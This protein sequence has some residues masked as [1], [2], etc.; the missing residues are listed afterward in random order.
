[1]SI[2]FDWQ[3][4][5]CERHATI[6][7][8]NYYEEFVR[9]GL[10]KNVYGRSVGF[11]NKMIVCPNNDCKEVVAATILQTYKPGSYSAY[12]STGEFQQIFNLKPQ[13][14]AKQFPSYVPSAVIEDYEEACKIKDLSPKSS[15]T[16]ARRALQGMIRD[17]HNVKGKN[18][19]YQ[20]I[21]AIKGKID[22]LLWDAIDSVRK[23]GNIGAH[24]EKDID[25][26]IE[27]EP[28]EAEKLIWLIELLVKEWYITR[29]TRE[30][31]LAFIKS[32]SDKKQE[33]KKQPQKVS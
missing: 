15:A 26:I 16:L 5:Y 30:Q 13:G 14:M 22:P 27:V 8:Q 24:M 4:P 12:E 23:I 2:S 7:E 10:S 11:L 31:H 28:E 19:L 29:N 32:T 1:M 18:N 21:E 33:I 6:T 25:V 9:T 17:F 3:C 20:E